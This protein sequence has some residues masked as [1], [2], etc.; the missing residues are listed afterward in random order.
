MCV[1]YRMV[2]CG[3]PPRHLRVNLPNECALCCS[4]PRGTSDRTAAGEGGREMSVNG[5]WIY[6][7]NG[8]LELIEPHE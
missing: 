6:V 1:V 5:V 3:Y 2:V 7:C 4:A 8:A